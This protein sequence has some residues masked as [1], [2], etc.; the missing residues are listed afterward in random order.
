M[1]FQISNPDFKIFISMNLCLPF[2]MLFQG[3]H[4]VCRVGTVF[5]WKNVFRVH[6]SYV[7]FQILQIGKYFAALC[8]WMSSRIVRKT[9]QF[10]YCIF[11]FPLFVFHFRYTF[12]F[13]FFKFCF[14]RFQANVSYCCAVLSLLVLVYCVLWRSNV[15]T[16][17]T[18][19]F[20]ADMYA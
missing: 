17:I 6:G 16:F 14:L 9:F 12:C 5:T 3:I 4:P 13:C 8:T 20:D 18:L 1:Q 10:L 11:F 19:M 2:L 7:S 15:F